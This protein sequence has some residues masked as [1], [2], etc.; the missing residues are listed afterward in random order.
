[1]ANGH[2]GY[3]RPTHPAA[4]SGPGRLSRRTDGRQPVRELPNAKYGEGQAFED[5]QRMAPM[6]ESAGGRAAQ[7]SMAAP[8]LSQIVPMD[9][10]SQ[11][12]DQP[13]TAG[14]PMGDGAGSTMAP[15]QPSLTPEQAQRLRA[16]IPTLVLLASREDAGPST[17]Q[18]VRQL[19]AELG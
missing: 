14:L 2:G 4:A 10:P 18:F 17:K 11:L 9:A 16:Y 15:Q 7:P 5:A 8:D 6:A 12:P 3:R 1:M 13:V 19:R